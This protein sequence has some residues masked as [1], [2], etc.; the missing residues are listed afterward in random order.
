MCGLQ[1]EGVRVRAMVFK[2]LMDLVGYEHLRIGGCDDSMMF[3][4][5]RVEPG[6]GASAGKEG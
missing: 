4:G 3:G 5:D 1:T 2:V 6:G